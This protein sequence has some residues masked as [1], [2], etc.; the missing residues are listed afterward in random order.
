MILS[1]A[2]T[3]VTR[4]T[5]IAMTMGD[6]LMARGLMD[7]AHFCYLMASAPLGYYTRKT[8]KLVLLGSSQ[9]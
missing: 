7:A 8:N 4:D 2:T 5:K 9:M 3:N 6:T 1:N